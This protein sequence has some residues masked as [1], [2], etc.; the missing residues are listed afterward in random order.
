MSWTGLLFGA[1]NARLSTTL[2]AVTANP[3]NDMRGH[4]ETYPVTREGNCSKVSWQSP[5]LKNSDYQLYVD[6]EHGTQGF[7]F[8]LLSID[9]EE[10]P[11]PR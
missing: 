3:A 1:D 6:F 9:V 10:V 2:I 7:G 8:G 11:G 5:L 4:F